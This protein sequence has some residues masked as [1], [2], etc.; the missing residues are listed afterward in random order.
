[1]ENKFKVGDRVECISKM[2]YANIGEKGTI[3]KIGNNDV[4]VNWDNAVGGWDSSELK[5]KNGHGEY[6]P[7]KFLKLLDTDANEIII[8]QNTTILKK[9]GKTYTTTCK[10][11]D[12]FDTEKGVMLTLLKS[13]GVTYQE[14][15]DLVKNA[16]IIA[17][18]NKSKVEEYIKLIKRVYDFNRVKRR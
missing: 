14:I 10:Q 18:K 16:K 2:N 1:M 8:N 12:T 15:A 3:A 9:N 6:M 7:F 5:I 4:I 17:P 11:D 13:F